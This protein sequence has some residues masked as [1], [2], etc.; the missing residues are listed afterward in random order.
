MP[1]SNLGNY[2][3][4]VMPYYHAKREA[5]LE[6]LADVVDELFYKKYK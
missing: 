1:Y 4:R 3:A 2:Q 5:Y 6:R